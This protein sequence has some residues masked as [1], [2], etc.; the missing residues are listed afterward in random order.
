[1]PEAGR[2]AP[3]AD[4]SDGNG[5]IDAPANDGNAVDTQ[6]TDA[7]TPDASED[8]AIEAGVPDTDGATDA[9]DDG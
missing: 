2:D 3:N 4:T 7:P 8:T 6:M 9:T 5:S 1:M